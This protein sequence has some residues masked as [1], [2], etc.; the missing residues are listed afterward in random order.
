MANLMA[1]TPERADAAEESGDLDSAFRMWLEISSK[2]QTSKSYFQLARLALTLRKWQAAETALLRILEINPNL[3]LALGMLGAL[4]LNRTDGGR[5]NNL[6][7]AK[8]WLLRSIETAKTAP[9]LCLLGTVYSHL[10]EKAKAQE[11][12]WTAIEVDG[13]YEEAYFNLGI[14]AAKDGNSERAENLLAKAIQ[15][16]PEYFSAHGRLAKLLRKQGRYPEAEREFRRCVEIDPSHYLSRLYLASVLAV[17]G[18][19][20]E[21]EYQFRKAI[22]IRPGKAVGMKLFASYLESLSRKDEADKLRARLAAMN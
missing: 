9:T 19:Q 16:D 3:P 20:V 2:S 7:A 1:A 12:W 22:A 8:T 15:I 14:L 18:R 5:A 17:L 11:A 6:E 10:S 13:Q 4:F 21:A